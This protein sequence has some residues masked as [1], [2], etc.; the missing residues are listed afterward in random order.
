MKIRFFIF[1]ALAGATLLMLNPPTRGS[2]L[3][4]GDNIA[5]VTSPAFNSGLPAVEF[6]SSIGGSV[7]AVAISD[8]IAYVG[9]GAALVTLDV[10]NP[11]QPAQLSRLPLP[12]LVGRNAGHQGSWTRDSQRPVL[13][14]L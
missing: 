13:G 14:W 6:V 10:S 3:T 2:S 5:P 1:L 12:D 7:R 4:P 11:F 9:A 8:T